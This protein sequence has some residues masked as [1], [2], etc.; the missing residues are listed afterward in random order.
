VLENT[1][2]AYNQH[3]LHS[4]VHYGATTSRTVI[5][6]LLY[7]D[8]VVFRGADGASSGSACERLIAQ[9][10]EGRGRALISGT[11]THFAG[12]MD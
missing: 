10:A 9:T 8:T 4:I 12:G 7:R 3:V 5:S 11:K 2:V 6:N 1:S